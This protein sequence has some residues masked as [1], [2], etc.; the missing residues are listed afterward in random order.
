MYVCKDRTKFQIIKGKTIMKKRFIVFSLILAVLLMASSSAYGLEVVGTTPKDGFTRSQPQNMAVKIKFDEQMV[1]AADIDS[2]AKLFKIT[3]PE[4]NEQGFSM[5]YS[6]KYPNELWLLLDGDLQTNTE[7]KVSIGS[8]IVSASGSETTGSQTMS[9]KTR[10]TSKDNTISTI[11][12]IGMMGLMVFMT[13]FSSKKKAK[14]NQVL[15][16]AQAEK[17]NPYKIAKQKKWT[18]EQAQA[19][20]DKEKEKARKAEAKALE[21]KRKREA[22]TA[23]EMEEINREL[24]SE[25]RRNGWFRVK[26]KETGSFKAHGHAIPRSILKK[27]AAKRKAEEERAKKYAKNKK[28]K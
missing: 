10:N 28:K 25:E 24:D 13:V 26:S 5:V 11:M 23:A 14:E 18:L 1:G 22:I 12:M 9:F 20:V 2:N 8:G 17:L 27:N 4:G 7:Y 21:E 16:V 19:Y 3:D 15:T 6:E